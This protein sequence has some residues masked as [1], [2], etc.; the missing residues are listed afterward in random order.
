MKEDYFEC[1]MLFLFIK[2]VNEFFFFIY[3]GV[4]YFGLI[5]GKI[6]MK[7]LWLC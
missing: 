6:V 1:F 4:Y 5:N 7:K 3:I 2:R